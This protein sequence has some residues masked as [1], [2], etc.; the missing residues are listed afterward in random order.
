MGSLSAYLTEN[1][2]PLS[3]SGTLSCLWQAF[4]ATMALA[5]GFAL[6]KFRFRGRAFFSLVFMF[7]IFPASLAVSFEWRESLAGAYGL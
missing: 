2:W 1:T 5:G 6:A 4:L 3:I 7:I